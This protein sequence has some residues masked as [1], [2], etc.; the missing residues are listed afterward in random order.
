VPRLESTHDEVLAP[1]T[2]DAHRHCC[3]AGLADPS[4]RP[5]W[6]GL[7]R[8]AEVG[9]AASCPRLRNRLG[10]TCTEERARVLGATLFMRAPP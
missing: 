2:T 1:A 6:V 4:E 8:S 7:S 5:L 9:L 3:S 10:A